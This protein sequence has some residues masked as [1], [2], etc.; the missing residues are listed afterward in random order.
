MTAPASGRTADENE[1]REAL[2]TFIAD[3]FWRNPRQA[4]NHADALLSGPLAP[5]LKEAATA[6]KERDEARE[7]IQG[8]E[9]ASADKRRLARMIDVAMHGEEGAAQQPSLCD[10]VGPANELRKRAEAAEASAAHLRAENANL[11]DRVREAE[12]DADHF[13]A[14][15]RCGRI[16]MQGSAGVDT[17]TGERTY[18]EHPGAVHFGAEFWVQ[19]EDK[20]SNLTTW[21][22]HCLRALAED[23][24]AY[25]AA[26]A[27]PL[28]DTD[29]G[30]KGAP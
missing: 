18:A 5:I 10:L 11:R 14:L 24:L 20:P 9:E 22:R 25:E 21:G 13:R 15:M 6:R 17:K 28:P 19:P 7:E 12:K 4:A 2:I 8:H 3:R 26:K 23:I 1:L 27:A 30:G 29:T 16:K